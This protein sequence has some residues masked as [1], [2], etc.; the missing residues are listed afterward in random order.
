MTNGP[1][2]DLVRLPRLQRAPLAAVSRRVAFAFGLVVFVA[3]VVRLGRG[4][5]VDVTG[6]PISFPQCFCNWISHSRTNLITLT[7]IYSPWDPAGAKQIL[8]PGV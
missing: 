6:D 3:V 5:Y 7:A 4:G 1:A 8:A 2:I